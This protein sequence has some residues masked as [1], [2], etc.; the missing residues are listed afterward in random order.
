MSTEDTAK[1]NDVLS[2]CANCGKG[3]EESDK[4]KACT[5]CKLV[6]Y[7]NREC[8]I[9]HRPQHKKECRK[10]AAELHDIELFKQ[11]PP[12]EDCPICFVR[13]PLVTTGFRYRSCCGK[14]ICNGC[15]RAPIYDDQGNIVD[16]RKCPFCRMP[17]PRSEV[18]NINKRV[19]AGDPLA[20]YNMGNWYRGGMHGFPQDMDKAM[21]LWQRA[22]DR[23]Y[24]V[25]YCNIGY[26][27]K[28]GQGSIEVDEG[29]ARHYYELGAIKGDMLTRH[30]L[31]GIMEENAGNF[32]RALKH[33]MIAVK[34][35][36]IESL[37]KIKEMYSHGDATKEEYTKALR[38]YQTYLGEIKSIQRDEA[39]AFDDQYRY[40]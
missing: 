34:G 12:R 20:I 32:D 14:V 29:K 26:A 10:R 13:L 33:Y 22:G 39:A 35:G 24:P 21:E 30:N 17:P 6:K 5:A 23:G 9:A 28:M 4:L 27:Y 16:N 11:P 38:A 37:H 15:I 2:V 25:A 7:C 40:F 31:G 8:Q 3:E 19:E 36:H 18:E 1:D